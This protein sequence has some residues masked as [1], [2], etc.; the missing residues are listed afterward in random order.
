MYPLDASTSIAPTYAQV[1]TAWSDVQRLGYGTVTD[2]YS[3][4]V[5]GQ[6][7]TAMTVA[8]TKAPS[9]LAGCEKATDNKDQGGCFGI[10][11]GTTLN[12]A[13]ID[14]RSGQPPNL[15]YESHNTTNT[16]DAPAVAAEFQTGWAPC[17]SASRQCRTPRS[18]AIPYRGAA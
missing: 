14:R 18:P 4:T 9:G 8:L 15:L 2:A 1:V 7:A 13:I 10:V 17:S 3:I 16:A 11:P 12:L 5:D 6:Q